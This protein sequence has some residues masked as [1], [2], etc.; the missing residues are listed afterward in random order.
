[1]GTEM[2]LAYLNNE[3]DRCF[4]FI[5]GN[6]LDAIYSLMRTGHDDRVIVT[7][8]RPSE[9][10]QRLHISSEERTIVPRHLS[11]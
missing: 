5:N 7:I 6:D 3:P 9:I 10:S 11:G 2:R 8:N 1:M 4:W